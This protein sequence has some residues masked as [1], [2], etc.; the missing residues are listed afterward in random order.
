MGEK[1]TPDTDNQD[2]YE[3]E[4][5]RLINLAEEARGNPVE[6]EL[7]AGEDDEQE[8]D[9]IIDPA[10]VLAER[11]DDEDGE[12]G[13]EPN[14]GD[15]DDGEGQEVEDDGKSTIKLFDDNQG[16]E[17]KEFRLK[18]KGQEIVKKMTDQQVVDDLQKAH[19]YDETMRLITP[20]KN[21]ANAI[22]HDRTFAGMASEYFRTGKV[23]VP[24][25]IRTGDAGN[26]S[27][28]KSFKLKSIDEYD[29]TD[30]KAAD[31][32]F[33]DN[34]NNFRQQIIS[35]IKGGGQEQ[36]A[37]GQN[38]AFD[39]NNEGHTQMQAAELN[40]A[41]LARTTLQ[42]KDPD[43]YHAVYPVMQELITRLDPQDAATINE[44]ARQGNITGVVKLYDRASQIYAQRQKAA[45]GGNN[46]TGKKESANKRTFRMKSTGRGV[47]K[48]IG[49]GDAIDP[50]QLPAKE[51]ARVTKRVQWRQ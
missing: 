14:D 31:K 10:K 45:A 21:L 46:Q 44:Q 12:Q 40:T 39:F 13:Q 3:K 27:E 32:W 5:L 24:D 2:A 47:P 37:T 34:M 23:T 22:M 25:D 36:Q 49:K 8:D 33:M 43:N 20:Y 42:A 35:E 11:D 9:G 4:R 30:P 16:Q 1:T 6:G 17:A 26:E 41:N 18:F 28:G 38:E 15:T 48:T 29:G 19:N 50:W 51:F 7:Q